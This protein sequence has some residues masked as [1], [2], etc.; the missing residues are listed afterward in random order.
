MLDLTAPPL[1]HYFASRPQP[2]DG[3]AAAMAC[4]D[5]L[6]D[7]AERPDALLGEL[8]LAYARCAWW[9]P[10]DGGERVACAD[11]LRWLLA[12]L[13]A[14]AGR[15]ERAEQVRALESDRKLFVRVLREDPHLLGLT[16]QTAGVIM[17]GH[18]NAWWPSLPAGHPVVAAAEQKA[19]AVTGRDLRRR[20]LALY[21][22]V[23]IEFGCTIDFEELQYSRVPV[24]VLLRDRGLR[25]DLDPDG[26]DGR[27]RPAPIRTRD[28]DVFKCRRYRQRIAAPDLVP[29][30]AVAAA[31]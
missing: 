31:T 2:P 18:S 10:E 1:S 25:P 9:R 22:E 12:W 27:L 29:P 7:R 26:P 30:E 8:C 17:A 13:D 5:A 15:Q 20:V 6:L 14:G 16:V 23:R 4:L 19:L 24:A 11:P 28:D 21:P 3:G